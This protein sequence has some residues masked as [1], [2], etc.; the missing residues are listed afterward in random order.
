MAFGIIYTGSDFSDDAIPVDTGGVWCESYLR[1]QHKGICYQWYSSES[2]AA[3][4]AA[5]YNAAAIKAGVNSRYTSGE[6]P[7]WIILPDDCKQDDRRA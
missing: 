6:L 2:R 7:E 4:T 5:E 3:E 1:S